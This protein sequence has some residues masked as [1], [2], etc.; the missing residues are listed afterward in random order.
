MSATAVL[1][2]PIRRNSAS[3][4][5]TIRARVSSGLSRTCGL[6]GGWLARFVNSDE[7]NNSSLVRRQVGRF[8]QRYHSSV[9]TL[10]EK[11]QLPR[12]IGRRS[13]HWAP[14]ANLNFWHWALSGRPGLND[15]VVPAT[16]R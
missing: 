8:R 11:S 3:A 5:S 15:L 9:L 16:I 1:A 2:N 7:F 14:D 12:R 10:V 6:I 4:V 13:L